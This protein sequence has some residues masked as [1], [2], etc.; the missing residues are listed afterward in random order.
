MKIQHFAILIAC[1]LVLG[2]CKKKTQ[3]AYSVV[4]KD[5]VF[6]LK[7][8]QSAVVEGEDLRLTFTGVPEE[9][10]CPQGVD[11]FQEG[12]VRVTLI[13]VNAGNSQTIE[14]TRKASEKGTVTRSF[15]KFK[16][17]LNEVSPYPKNGVKTNLEDYSLKLAVRKSS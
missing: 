17:Q 7:M 15:G 4:K 3:P 16:I 14:F 2:S 1:I 10:R 6:D 12:Q 8:S 9:S 13:A 5:Q 11:C